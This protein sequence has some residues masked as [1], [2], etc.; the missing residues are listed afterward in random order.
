[1]GQHPPATITRRE[2][3]LRLI[4]KISIEKCLQVCTWLTLNLFHH[5]LEFEPFFTKVEA[6]TPLGDEHV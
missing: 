4:Y 5:M 3:S 2:G 6:L 1:M